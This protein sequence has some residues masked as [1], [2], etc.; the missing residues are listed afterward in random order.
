R[1]SDLPPV[2]GT[3]HILLSLAAEEQSVAGRVLT[4]LG[5]SLQ[6]L[7]HQLQE[8]MSGVAQARSEGV[9][10]SP[11]AKRVLELAAEEAR[12]LNHNYIGTEHLLLALLRE[13]EGVA[14]RLLQANDVSLEAVREAV[15]ETLAPGMAGKP[16]AVPG[17][18]PAQAGGK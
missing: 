12:E 15:L 5:L 11:R 2:V 4:Q 3:E 17:K 18:S 13:G 14:A 10:F 16:G 6:K 8:A 7:Y 1:S 9:P